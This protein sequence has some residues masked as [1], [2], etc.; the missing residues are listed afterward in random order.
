MDAFVEIVAGEARERPHAFLGPAGLFIIMK[1]VPNLRVEME[2][3]ACHPFVLFR[4]TVWDKGVPQ[5]AVPYV[6]AGA[7]DRLCFGLPS[8]STSFIV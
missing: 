2:A 5:M 4:A 1:C 7:F 6:G 8:E 3:A